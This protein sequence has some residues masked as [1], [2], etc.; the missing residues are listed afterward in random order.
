MSFRSATGSLSRSN[1][2]LV[3]LCLVVHKFFDFLSE[4]NGGEGFYIKKAMK[5][6]LENC[7]R[8]IQV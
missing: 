1:A 4:D 2:R 7:H 6:S 3:V 8:L 5:I